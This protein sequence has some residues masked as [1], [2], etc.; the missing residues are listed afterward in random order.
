MKKTAWKCLSACLLILAATVLFCA[1]GGVKKKDIVGTYRAV[2][3]V[4]DELNKGLAD[5]GATLQSDVNADFI[6]TLNAD[7][8]FSL[9]LDGEGFRNNLSEMMEKE[10]P[11]LIKTMLES[12][13]V[14]EDM[15]ETIAQASGY[16]SYDAF[17]EDL[18]QTVMTE[19]GE[20]F[21]GTLESES[22]FEGT[23]SI[24][25]GTLTLNGEVNEVSGIEQGSL[26]ED[27]TISV[28]MKT[29]DGTPLS[30]VFTKE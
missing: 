21:A 16:D 18:K 2:Y 23:Y 28:S 29:E 15:Y 25:G 7:D 1:C 20:E 24:S 5:I 27:G 8:S 6:L 19:V 13:G 22:H 4:K 17:V 14:T 30:L 9:D 12:E 3:N 26:N 11:E 10:A